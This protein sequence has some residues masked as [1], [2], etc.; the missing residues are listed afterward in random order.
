MLREGPRINA[1]SSTPGPA[2]YIRKAVPNP[3][4][5][6]CQCGTRYLPSECNCGRQNVNSIKDARVAAS[7][8]KVL[9][10]MGALPLKEAPRGTH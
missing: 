6:E 5:C 7:F 10:L 3:T 2:A 9:N 4:V 8:K 1:G